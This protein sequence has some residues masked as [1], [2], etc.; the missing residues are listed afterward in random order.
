MRLFSNNENQMG[1]KNIVTALEISELI[2][3][4]SFHDLAKKLK[5]YQMSNSLDFFIQKDQ[6]T[7]V[8]SHVRFV[9]FQFLW[10]SK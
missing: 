9:M 4:K 8:S 10:T 7:I 2:K 5:N 6:R 1:L 3:E